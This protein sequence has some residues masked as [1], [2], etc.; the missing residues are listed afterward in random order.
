MHTGVVLVRKKRLPERYPLTLVNDHGGP[1]SHVVRAQERDRTD[2]G[3]VL[4][5]LFRRGL[6]GYVQAL[7]QFY[8]HA[9]HSLE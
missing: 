8:Y 2:G 4:N 6:Y 5:G 1:Q 3:R 7:S 9:L